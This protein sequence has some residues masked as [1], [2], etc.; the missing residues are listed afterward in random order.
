MATFEEQGANHTKVTWMLRPTKCHIKTMPGGKY[1]VLSTGEV[2]E[3]TKSDSK[4]NHNL[5]ATFEHLRGL[6]R[7]NFTNGAQNQA[8]IT[9]TYK[10]NMRNEVTV[11]EDFKDFMR[12][13]RRYLPDHQLEYISVIEPQARGAWHLHVML[14]STNQK[15]LWIDKEKLKDLW[16][17][18]RGN[19]YIE[20]LKSDDVGAYYVTY[21][22]H[23]YENEQ[24]KVSP[25]SPTF[26]EIMSEVERTSHNE[27][28]RHDPD[29]PDRMKLL[30]KAKFKG[31][32]LH[33][34]PKG[35]KFYRC[36]RGIDRPKKSKGMV[37]EGAEY[38][39]LTYSQT[40]EI[41]AEDGATLNIITRQH[42]KKVQQ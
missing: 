16:G 11:K 14:K 26:D 39:K 40:H 31:Q 41:K 4:L 2:F 33:F 19:A 6:I 38:G 5:R 32:R 22:T 12:S 29:A 13:L 17:R 20:R 24:I 23:L 37:F 35:L 15:D 9:L 34:Y 36:S 42:Y 27:N 21:F 8:F 30:S 3:M 25:L 10:V 7:T 18:E 1:E 28:A